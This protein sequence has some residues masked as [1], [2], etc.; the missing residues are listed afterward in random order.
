MDQM[1]A[2]A[3]RRALG[4]AA[5][6]MAMAWTPCVMAAGQ[7]AV[8]RIETH[9]TPDDKLLLEITEPGSTTPNK[10][11]VQLRAKLTEGTTIRI[12][13]GSMVELESA[14][15]EKIRSG[16]PAGKLLLRST[17]ARG[18]AYSVLGGRWV[19]NVLKRLDFFNVTTQTVSAQTRGTSFS[20]EL[21]E[22]AG[23]ARYRVD[24]GRIQI[25]HPLLARIAAPGGVREARLQASETLAA[26]APQKSFALTPESYLLEFGSYA[27]AQAQFEARLHAAEQANDA[28]A[29][30][31]M[32]IALGD[33]HSVLGAPEQALP[34]YSSAY[35]IVRGP[36]DGY[37][38]AVLLGRL[39]N[40]HY[41]IGNFAEAIHYYQDSMR[42]HEQQP[43]SEGEF[44]V[45]E[46]GANLAAA[47]LARGTY[48]C[49]A[50]VGE[51]F[52]GELQARYGGANHPAYV[53]FHG[54]IG[55]AA[56]G[57]GDFPRAAKE[58]EQ[59]LTIV[60][61]L[62]SRFRKADGLTYHEEVAEALNALGWDHSALRRFDAAQSEHRD[63]LT[64]ADALFAQPHVLKADAHHGFGVVLKGR[65]RA[66][67]A[68]AEHRQALEILAA[69]PRD[70]I[71]LGLGRLYL[72]E[73][74]LAARRPNDAVEALEQ[75]RTILQEKIPDQ[76]H[77][78]F[79]TLH[80]D[81]AAAYRAWGA[82]ATQATTAAATARDLDA[83]VQAR[84][85][86]CLK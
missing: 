35:D 13:D 2:I 70:V 56:Y 6:T 30:V 26:G 15:G 24:E 65:G 36:A 33:I 55:S 59:A 83:Q 39:G 18:E 42:L 68:V 32:L 9:G 29:K 52:L 5:V 11:Q 50:Q 12:P 82:H 64:I 38:Q 69:A 77:P 72:G 21:D 67:A 37:W 1:L 74:L 45:E 71:R 3:T 53:G 27:D 81:L 76:V 86:A 63:A 41:R 57:L 62:R 10:V 8:S 7:W 85:A 75:A 43:A 66:V 17:S 73:A 60:R 23:V 54:V 20:A 79:V 16:T 40:A 46:Q 80:K 31:N 61:R 48:R 47:Y 25:L 44:T 22:A 28:D 84:E 78:D 14:N 4:A 51:Q 19:F 58:H 34:A 49:A